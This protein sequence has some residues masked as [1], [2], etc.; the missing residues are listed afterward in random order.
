MDVPYALLFGVIV[1][2]LYYVPHVGSI[3]AAVPPVLLAA[4]QRDSERWLWV[5]VGLV[6]ISNL[7]GNI[8]EPRVIGWRLRLS[9]FF[10][11]VSL[12][13]WGWLWGIVGVVLAVPIAATIRIICAEFESLRFFGLL[14]GGDVPRMPTRRI[15]TA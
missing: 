8:L 2:A 10:V 1:F 12:F 4:L 13:F 11:L 7:V 14:I 5:L 9:P 6:V 15:R 3:I